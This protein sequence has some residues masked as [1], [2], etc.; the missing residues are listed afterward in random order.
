MNEF[1]ELAKLRPVTAICETDQML[2]QGERPHYFRSGLTALW[3][4]K[5]VLRA[6]CNLMAEAKPIGRILDVGCGGG[7]VARFLRV[8]FPDATVYV[9][10]F[11]KEEAL[12]CCENLGCALAPDELPADTYDLVWLG[13]VFTHHSRDSAQQLLARLLPS[14]AADG[15]L[16]FSMQGRHGY[17]RLKQLLS[18]PTFEVC[19]QSYHLPK[20][21]VEELVA[22]WETDG[23]GY[24]SY[25]KDS[26]Y[27]VTIARPYWYVKAATDLADVTQIFFQER[28]LQEHQDV[29]GFMRHRLMT[30]SVFPFMKMGEHLASG[31]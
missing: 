27:G 29:L 18:Q 8:G 20:E 9:C 25:S 5:N 13:S 31:Y 14:L 12:W 24:V 19:A 6:R 3:T 11:R 1:Q 16:A 15:V 4:I 28:A 17:R 10:D 30:R 7:R 21:R 23:Y 2:G 22:G 26:D